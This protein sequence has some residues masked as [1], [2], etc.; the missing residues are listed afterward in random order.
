MK[1]RVTI[2]NEIEVP[3]VTNGNLA[4][5]ELKEK[6]FEQCSSNPDKQVSKIEIIHGKHEKNDTFLFRLIS[7]G[8]DHLRP[9]R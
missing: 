5:K 3:D 2:I 9:A 8:A 4:I 7:V 1:I 6:Y